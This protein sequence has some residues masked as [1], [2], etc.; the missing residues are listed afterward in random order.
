MHWDASKGRHST[1]PRSTVLF[2]VGFCV[3]TPDFSGK[4]WPVIFGKSGDSSEHPK[5]AT[6]MSCEEGR[7]NCEEKQLPVVSVEGWGDFSREPGTSVVLEQSDR[8][9]WSSKMRKS[10]SDQ[11]GNGMG[12]PW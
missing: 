12:D 7:V 2:C 1:A 3:Q 6:W 4:P 5:K 10:D 9:G 11:P 8:P